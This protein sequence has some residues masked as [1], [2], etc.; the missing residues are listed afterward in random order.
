MSRKK[1]LATRVYTRTQLNA[2][3]IF[4]AFLGLV[5]PLLVQSPHGIAANVGAMAAA[6]G[7]TLTVGVAANEYNTLAQQLSVK[8]LS[9]QEREEALRAKET[10]Y[11]GL[12][13][14][15]LFGLASF[16]LSI[17]LCALI[18][19]N[20]YMDWRRGRKIMRPGKFQ[21]DLR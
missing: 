2:L 4:V 15:D 19:L 16:V 12:S 1:K 10:R 6:T 3:G 13:L 21:V 14:G 5:H 9:L 7:A 17:I 20:F 18:G 11:A 8:Q